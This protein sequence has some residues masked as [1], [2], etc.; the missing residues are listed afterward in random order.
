MGQNEKSSRYEVNRKVRIVITQ[1][2]GDLSRVDYSYLGK[3]VY[4]SGELSR[5]DRD[6]SSRE[7]ESI[8]T[9]I[10]A[11]PDVTDIIF[12]LNNWIVESS[13]NTWQ[14]RP[15]KK[16]GKLHYGSGPSSGTSGDTT[17]IIENADELKSVLDD[18]NQAAAKS[19]PP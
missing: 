19:S 6:F 10:M 11:I 17:L 3:T 8:A 5:P 14:I 2:D 15:L 18:I 1:H 13:G 4:L 9:D 12:D 7:I 16:A